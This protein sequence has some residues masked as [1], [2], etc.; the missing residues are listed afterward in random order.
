MAKVMQ[1]YALTRDQTASVMLSGNGSV[2]VKITVPYM[3]VKQLGLI[4]KVLFNF[5]ITVKIN[6]NDDISCLM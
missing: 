6:V 3:S 5:I 2:S 1:S 4:K